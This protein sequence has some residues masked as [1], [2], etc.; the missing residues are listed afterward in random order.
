MDD[1]DAVMQLFLTA[2]HFSDFVI[3]IFCQIVPY[4]YIL[5]C[6]AVDRI[7][8]CM[9]DEVTHLNFLIQYQSNNA[10]HQNLS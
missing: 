3:F 5:H 1:L 6:S 2:L 10:H 7:V 4:C 9:S 8:V